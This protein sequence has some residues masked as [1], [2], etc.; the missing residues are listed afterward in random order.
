MN[1]IN[2][3]ILVFT[4]GVESLT[5]NERHYTELA[6]LVTALY[7]V[8]IVSM[9]S[10]L[11]KRDNV[12]II[13]PPRF[14]PYL[15][16]ALLLSLLHRRLWQSVDVVRSTTQREILLTLLASSVWGCRSVVD[17]TAPCPIASKGTA[18]RGGRLIRWLPERLSYLLADAIV[19]ETA[20]RYLAIERRRWVRAEHFVLH[21][22]VASDD[23]S[24]TQPPE[25]RPVVI[26][27]EP[28]V[29]PSTLVPKITERGCVILR[30]SDT[31]T[32]DTPDGCRVVHTYERHW[33]E[34]IDLEQAQL[35]IIEGGQ[36]RLHAVL[37]AMASG[38][39]VVTTG[40]SESCEFVD[41]EID[42]VVVNGDASSI[43]QAVTA[44]C[45]DAERRERLGDAARA[46]SRRLHGIERGVTR[47]LAVYYMILGQ[48][49]E[50]GGI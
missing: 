7:I 18:S 29:S 44:L 34:Q 6:A 49:M 11:R 24:V 39:P 42:G 26:D 14:I 32:A 3:T 30:T 40:A 1:S 36:G 43:G 10:E 22:S 15:L 33:T 46:K 19:S 25:D 20:A 5:R 17:T 31:V 48:P 45:T 50:G 27:A 8:G 38:L 28:N 35:V 16:F 12:T 2:A 37:Q 13:E 41:D 9:S 21:P 47:E 4:G 23:P